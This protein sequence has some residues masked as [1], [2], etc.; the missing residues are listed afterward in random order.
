MASQLSNRLKRV[1]RDLK[2]KYPCPICHGKGKW[3]VSYVRDENQVAP[4]LVGC[5]GCG[6][7]NHITV[8]YVNKP[9]PR[10]DQ[11]DTAIDN[12]NIDA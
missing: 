11:D 5:E 3:V 2:A 12:P 10:L 8:K 1:A 7:A 4:P 9:I 6:E